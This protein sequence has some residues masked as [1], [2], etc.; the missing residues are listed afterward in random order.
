VT[1]LGYETWEKTYFVSTIQLVSAAQ[2]LLTVGLHR[3]SQH[4]QQISPP[5]WPNR[6]ICAHSLWLALL[7]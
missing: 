2:L 7:D 3:Q 4:H 6:L 5:P 1:E